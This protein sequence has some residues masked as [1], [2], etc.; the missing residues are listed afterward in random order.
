MEVMN[1]KE[2]A[3]KAPVTNTATTEQAKKEQ[4]ERA[5]FFKQLVEGGKLM[6]FGG[7]YCGNR[8]NER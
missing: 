7:C 1:G 5:A 6:Y 4:A 2:S 3:A 8:S